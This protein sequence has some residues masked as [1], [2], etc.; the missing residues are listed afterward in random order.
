MSHELRTPLN[1]IL[2]FT[3]FVAMGLYGPINEEQHEALTISL[4]SSRHLLELI[5]D[6]LDMTK[7]QSG[8][9]NLLIE[10]D[11][12]M[13]NEIGSV[14][15]I[16][17]SLLRDKPVQL[18]ED[19]D[20]ELPFIAGD[21][22]RIKQILL[23]LL[24]NACKFTSTGSITLSVKHEPESL[25]FAVMDTGPGITPEDQDVIFEP[26]RQTQTGLQHSSGTGLGLHISKRLAE[27]HGGSLWVDSEPGQ[28]AAFF[29]RL[30]LQPSR[31]VT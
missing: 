17:K 10:T 11:I 7:I 4:E 20:P 3:E 5:N 26:F 18:I 31:T 14:V 24:S 6:V 19:I 9:L 21:K 2:N 8:M 27:A 23:N 29:L 15:A 22:R 30:P 28:G 12:D 16:A 13:H 1:A 25:L